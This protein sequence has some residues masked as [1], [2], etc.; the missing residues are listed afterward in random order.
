MERVVVQI[1]HSISNSTISSPHTI[2]FVFLKR[3]EAADPG[4]TDF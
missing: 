1:V 3:S 4:A 2:V